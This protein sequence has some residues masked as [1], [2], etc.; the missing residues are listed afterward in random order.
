MRDLTA[1]TNAKL[2]AGQ[3]QDVA[4][5]T[6]DAANGRG[7]A[8]DGPAVSRMLDQ[9]SRLML[10]RAD[11]GGLNLR[12]LVS[13]AK[14][15]DADGP[16][17]MKYVFTVGSSEATYELLFSSDDR[18]VSEKLRGV[19]DS[20]VGSIF[21]ISAADGAVSAEFSPRL[22]RNEVFE[23]KART[24]IDQYWGNHSFLSIMQD[25]YDQ[26][27]REFMAAAV[28]T[29]LKEVLDELDRLAVSCKYSGRSVG[30]G[31]GRY[32]LAHLPNGRISGTALAELETYEHALSSY[33]T[34]LYS[35][36]VRA[37]FKTEK[38]DET[39]LRY[40][41]MLEKRIAG[42]NRAVSFEKESSGT[43]KLLALFPALIEC[44]LG[45]TV[46]FDEAD[47]GIHDKLVRDLMAQVLPEVKGQL[48]LT[49]HST[50]L[51]NT[52]NPRNVF[53][54]TV[55][56]DGNKGLSSFAEIRKTARNNNN[57]DRYLNGT[58]GGVPIIGEVDLEEIARSLQTALVKK[59]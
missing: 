17:G 38:E 41:L 3:G 37:F 25:Q 57:R 59:M 4:K 24:L 36:V 20:N 8:A 7:S 40:T 52:A 27:N 56:L 39:Y 16:L 46:F 42:R 49:T 1:V 47:S 5:I 18:L 9:L 45:R 29:G 6:I 15:I 58:F 31:I 22:F 2:A 23:T 21:E 55:D 54:L 34:R 44:A 28:G 50:A 14:T 51:L 11:T 48:I 43:Q 30:S 19:I 12:A 35:D 53:V 10:T 26:N 32:I 13:E 33:F